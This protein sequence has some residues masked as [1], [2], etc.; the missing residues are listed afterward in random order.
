[1]NKTKQKKIIEAASEYLSHLDRIPDE[2]RFDV[3]GVV[4]DG[5]SEPRIN[6]IE[7][8]FSVEND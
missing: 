4:W 6:H 3:I 2:V 8:A 1:V 5:Q 7:S